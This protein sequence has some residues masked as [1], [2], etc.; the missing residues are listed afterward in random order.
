MNETIIEN[1]NSLVKPDDI[2]YNLGDVIMGN[3]P[4]SHL[5]KIMSRLN[6]KIHLIYGNHDRVIRKNVELK[7]L[8][9]STGSDFIGNIG[10]HQ[11]HLYHFP[12]GSWD[13][14]GRGC[15]NLFGH[16]HG[17]YTR[18]LGRQMDV[19]IDTNNFYP[20]NLD[21]VIALM[22]VISPEQVDHHTDK[23]SYH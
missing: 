13:S 9:E 16:C 4:L 17:T 10:G 5:P 6:G 12:C 1:H 8:F 22:D 18:V 11:F 21:E 15:I 19:G 7:R 14:I 23:T 20:Y 3:N 2:V